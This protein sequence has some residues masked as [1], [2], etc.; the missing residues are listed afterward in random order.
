MMETPAYYASKGE[1]TK[2]ESILSLISLKNT[3]KEFF[4]EEIDDSI[5]SSFLE[6]KPVEKQ[7][8]KTI[9]HKLFHRPS[10]KIALLG[11]IVFDI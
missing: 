9:L 2:A 7:S 3:G 10:L 6:D 8:V 11:G 1:M 4:L 5:Q